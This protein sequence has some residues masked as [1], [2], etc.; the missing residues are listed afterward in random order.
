MSALRKP[1]NETGV[2]H[3]ARPTGQK[4]DV[5]AFHAEISRRFPKILAK[6]AE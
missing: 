1:T 6:L 4:I 2:K 3:P 5:A